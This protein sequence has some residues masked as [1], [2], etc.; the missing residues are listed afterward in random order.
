MEKAGFV[1]MHEKLYKIPL[2]PWPKNK[3]LKEIGRLQ[4]FHWTSALEGWALWLL[5]K[6]GAPSPWTNDEVQAYLAKI[7]VELQNPHIHGYEYA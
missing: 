6:Y 2:G 5:T 4:Y 1:D 7:Q 3:I